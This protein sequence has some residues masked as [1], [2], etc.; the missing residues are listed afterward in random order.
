[1]DNEIQ[2]IRNQRLQ[3]LKD[4]IAREQN[5]EEKKKKSELEEATR[6][7]LLRRMLEPQARER[8]ARIG[9]VRPEYARAIEEQILSLGQRGQIK[10][11]IDDMTLKNILAKITPAK[12]ETKIERR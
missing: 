7:M 12:R 3:Q 10:K 11:R 8:L 1:M 5:E 4:Q 9:M 2:K 6:K